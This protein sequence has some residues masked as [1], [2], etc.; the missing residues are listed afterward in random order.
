MKRK[1]KVETYTIKGWKNTVRGLLISENKDWILVHH[2]PMDYELDG[3]KLY[4][5]KFVKK[6]V[7]KKSEALVERVLRLR[8]TSIKQ[9]KGFEFHKVSKT[10]KWCE[11]KYDLFEFQDHKQGQLFYG[12]IN[13]LDKK[14]LIIDSITKHG[15][16]Q[17][18]FDYT[19]NLDKIRSITFET[20]YFEAI[21]LMMHDGLTPKN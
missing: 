12:K 13:N 8:N 11:K 2:L 10:L 14:Q 20:D 19:F 6:R 21:R 9:P 7:S 17:E 15:E 5:K 16:I 18:A 1:L 3:Y 4:R